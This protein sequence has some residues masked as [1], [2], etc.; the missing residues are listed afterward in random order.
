MQDHVA[1]SKRPQRKE[2]RLLWVYTEDVK[3]TLDS[4]TWLETTRELRALGWQVTLLSATEAGIQEVRGVEVYGIPKPNVYLLRQVLFHVQVIRLLWRQWQN[5]DVV[6]FHQMSAPWILPFRF[7]R[8]LRGGIG[9]RLIMDTRTV[10][11]TVATTKDRLRAAFDNLMNHAANLLADGQTAI[12]QRMAEL[13]KIPARHLLGIWPSGVNLQTFTAAH[14]RQ[15]PG[16][17]TPIQLI[18]VGTLRQERNLMLMCQMLERANQAGMNF[19]LSIIGDGPERAELEHFAA[20]AGGCI[21]V[22]PPVPHD[23]VPALLA[24]AHVGILPFPDTLIFRV[25]SPIKLFEYMAAGLPIFATRIDCHTDVLGDAPYV[26]WAGS[27][28]A[29]EIYRALETCWANRANLADRGAAAFAA[30]E[31]WTWAHALCTIV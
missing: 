1:E 7:V 14:Q 25:S 18:Y 27:G 6:L 28:T 17:A 9:P 15:W 29:E 30:A 13:V 23:R 8:F 11:M 10:P 19:S 31:R 20:T 12:T 16:V 4:A 26:F 22:V 3:T 21:Q 24:Q 5:L 2:N